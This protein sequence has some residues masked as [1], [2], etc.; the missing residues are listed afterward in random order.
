MSV[1]T[2]AL[3]HG[4]VALDLGIASPDAHKAGPDCV[5]SM[6][7]RKVAHYVPHRD[8]LD[9]Q[10]I[11]HQPLVRS[12]CG[13]PRPRTTSI[14][15]A[16]ATRLSRRRGCSDRERRYRRLAAAA[17]TALWRRPAAHVVACWPDREQPGAPEGG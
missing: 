13:R 12:A 6:Y 2:G 14:L 15:R 5:A 8:A 17:G 7:A 11:T 10:N 9:H 4:L 16:L 3:D 1:L